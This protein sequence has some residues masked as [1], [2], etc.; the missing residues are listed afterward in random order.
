MRSRART[1]WKRRG[2]PGAAAVELV[3]VLPTFLFMS[4]A[5]TDYAR[6]FYTWATIADCARNGAFYASD[7]SFASS[8]SFRSVSEAALADATNLSPTPTVSQTSGIDGA[9]NSYVEV[10]VSTTF[11]PTTPYSSIPNSV[12]LSR[13]LRMVVTP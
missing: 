12:P 1:W 2:R 13:K 6:L 3:M 11:T 10:T 8:T 9:G 4:V 7:P 5:A